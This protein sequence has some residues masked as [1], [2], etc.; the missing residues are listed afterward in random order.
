MG[1]GAHSTVQAGE[2]KFDVETETRATGQPARIVTDTTVYS[3][4]RVLYRRVKTH[5]DLVLGPETDQDVLQARMRLQHRAVLEDLRTGALKFDQPGFS[6]Q[7]I[8]PPAPIE[9]PKGIEV[10]L[11]NSGR[12]LASGKA[13]LDIEVR[14]RSTLKPAAGVTVDVSME[15][16]LPAFRL[17]AGTDPRGRVSLEFPMPKLGLG[18]AE[19]VIRAS[20]A[21]GRDEVRFRLKPRVHVPRQAQ[22][23]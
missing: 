3:R 12:W 15:G 16:V 2:L 4:G 6:R 18:G 19:L 23:P 1:I 9:F 21:A 13:T 10:R 20:G 5:E 11:L 8:V 7:P 17:K 14:G 22:L